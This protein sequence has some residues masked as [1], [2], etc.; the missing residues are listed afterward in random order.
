MKVILFQMAAKILASRS[1]NKIVEQVQFAK[2]TYNL[3]MQ[4]SKKN[5]L[6]Q[7]GPSIPKLDQNDI[8][9]PWLL[10]YAHWSEMDFVVFL[11]LLTSVYC[12]SSKTVQGGIRQK[13]VQRSSLSIMD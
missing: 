3:F 6:I 5:L 8:K 4:F 12:H 10:S 2:I 1:V 11:K 9:Q 7:F 13:D